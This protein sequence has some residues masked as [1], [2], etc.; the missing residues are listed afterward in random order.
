MAFS[1]DEIRE[2]RGYFIRKLLAEKQRNDVLNAVEAE[3]FDFVLLDTRGREAFAGGHIH[4]RNVTPPQTE[5]R[6]GDSQ[7]RRS[8]LANS[9]YVRQLV[10]GIGFTIE[11]ALPLKDV[12]RTFGE[13]LSPKLQV[14]LV[15][16]QLKHPTRS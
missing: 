16:M 6:R 5:N 7:E 15:A 1:P 10:E 11:N 14:E 9:P 2:N 13:T 4:R 3:T 8:S 12:H